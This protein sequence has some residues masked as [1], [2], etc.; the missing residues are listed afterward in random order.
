MLSPITRAQIHTQTH[1][2]QPPSK[3]WPPTLTLSRKAV[4]ALQSLCL[5]CLSSAFAV[6]P[7]PLSKFN[8]YLLPTQTTRPKD[9]QHIDT[10]AGWAPE[11]AAAQRSGRQLR[12]PLGEKMCS[13]W[14]FLWMWSKKD[15][16][17]LRNIRK[18][19][20]KQLTAQ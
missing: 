13:T 20:E 4:D 15:K 1:I 14:L 12:R 6:S 7:H 8:F 19:P 5:L 11:P 18:M 3:F 16:Y 10:S 17:K 9:T 2:S